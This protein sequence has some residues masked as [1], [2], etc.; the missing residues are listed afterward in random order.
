MNTPTR[1]YAFALLATASAVAL[2]A[3]SYA[4]PARADAIT[5]GQA[6][7]DVAAPLEGGT[8]IVGQLRIDPHGRVSGVILRDGTEL[9]ATG[10]GAQSLA[11]FV[12]PGDRV[13]TPVGP[14]GTLEIEDLRSDRFIQLG[15]EAD[16]ARGGGPESQ[17]EVG[18]PRIDDASHLGRVR[19]TGRVRSMLHRPYGATSGFVMEDGTQVHVL[20]RLGRVV[21]EVITP[22]ESIV[23]EGRGTRTPFGTGLWAVKITQ[24]SGFVLIDL[25]RGVRAPELN[26]P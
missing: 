22:G 15:S 17:P 1:R 7:S 25:T 16:V 14:R 19:L 11:T 18:Y 12:Q 4:T 5:T 9:V 2:T 3:A 21:S 20:N 23:V 26:L 24:P 8:G 10:P 13:R 6:A